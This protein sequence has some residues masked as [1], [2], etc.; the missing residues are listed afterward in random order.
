[1]VKYSTNRNRNP[2]GDWKHVESMDKVAYDAYIVDE[3]VTI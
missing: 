2:I 1:M 3:K